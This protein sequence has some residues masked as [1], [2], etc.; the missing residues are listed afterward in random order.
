MQTD[1]RITIKVIC[2][3]GDQ[4]MCLPEIPASQWA[5]FKSCAQK[6]SER[7]VHSGNA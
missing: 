5:H 3:R 2:H 7:P 6:T 1:K 4:E